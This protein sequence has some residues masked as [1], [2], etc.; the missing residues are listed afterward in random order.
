M[1]STSDNK[2]I[3]LGEKVTLARPVRKWYR[4]LKMILAS[5]KYISAEMKEIVTTK[6]VI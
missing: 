1:I 6:K 2:L 5:E 4:Q 3:M